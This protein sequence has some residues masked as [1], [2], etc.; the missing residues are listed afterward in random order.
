MNPLGDTRP[1]AISEELGDDQGV[2]DSNDKMAEPDISIPAPP[3]GLCFQPHI[4]L[5]KRNEQQQTSVLDMMLDQP[6][7]L[8]YKVSYK[9]V[10]AY[11]AKN[12]CAE[13]M[14]EDDQ[15][16]LNPGIRAFR[17]QLDI[18]NL[19]WQETWTNTAHGHY[20]EPVITLCSVYDLNEYVDIQKDLKRIR[21]ALPKKYRGALGWYAIELNIAEPTSDDDWDEGVE[22]GTSVEIR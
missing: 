11:T 18:Q 3:V 16:T 7:Y 15:S 2:N 12:K 4:L 1:E 6:L 10:H 21:K 17:K 13:F 5:L 9:W 22:Y 14:K 20:T 19:H 8:G